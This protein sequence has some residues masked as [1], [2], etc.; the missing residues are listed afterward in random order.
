MTINRIWT[1]AKANVLVVLSLVIL[2]LFAAPN[3]I[4]VRALS[5]LTF[6][7]VTNRAAVD[8]NNCPIDGPTAM[9]IQINVTN[10][11]GTNFSDLTFAITAGLGPTNIADTTTYMF[12]TG[13][14]PSRYIASLPTGTTTR[15]Y[16]YVF[17]P[18]TVS[19]S[20]GTISTNIQVTASS[21]AFPPNVVS[22]NLTL[23]NSKDVSA[24]AG[25]SVLSHVIGAGAIPGQVIPLTVTYDLGNPAANAD[26]IINPVGARTFNAAC[27]QLIGNDITNVSTLTGITT[28]SD[29][30]LYFASGV[31]GPSSNTLT[32]IYYFQV[33]C[34]AGGGAGTRPT[35]FADY[36]SGGRDKY[37]GNFPACDTAGNPCNELPVVTNPLTI[38]KSASPSF[39]PAGGIV[40]YT[41]VITNTSA[42]ATKIDKIE[43]T[44]ATTP[45]TVTFQAIS[46]GSQVNAGNSSAVPL[47]GATGLIKFIGNATTSC[48]GAPVTCD[49]SYQLAAGSTLAL[50]YT[51]NVPAAPPGA[52]INTVRAY[53]GNVVLTGTATVLVGV[54]ATPTVTATFTPSATFTATNTATAT[55]TPSNT[56]TNTATFTPSNTAT[57]TATATATATNTATNTP[58]FT[59]SN[60][61][62]DTPTATLT[63]SNTAT[64]TPTNTATFTP[65][66]T[67]TNT[68]TATLTPSNTATD[69]PTNT[70][71]FTPSNT[72]T[73][74][75]TATL[76]PSNTATDTP[77]NTA[78][79]TP[80][81]TPTNTPT[82]TLTPSNTATDT[83]TNTPTFTPSNTATNTP[84][85]TLT[86]SSTATDTPT[87]TPSNTLT[88]T[89]T[90]TP[91]STATLTVTP[92]NT[93]TDTATFTAT[94][95]PSGTVT[96][97]VT[98]VSTATDTP[99]A[100]GTTVNTATATFTAS[101]TSAVSATSTNT[102]TATASGTIATA[103]NTLAPGNTPTSQVIVIDPAIVKLADLTLALPGENVTFTLT[104][105]NR[106]NAPATNVTVA[107]Q[108]PSDIFV[109]LSASTTKGSYSINGNDV[110]FTIGT[111]NPGEIVTM[112]IRTRVRGDVR[113][114]VDAVNVAV[115]RYSEGGPRT[116]TSS[117]T[118]RITSG[119]LPATGF[120][121]PEPPYGWILVG[122]GASLLI[123]VAWFVNKRRVKTS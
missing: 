37:T 65:S 55:S 27:F 92:V 28:A 38:T 31:N 16:Y 83:P 99:T 116:V 32:V 114:P 93:A 44:L 56:A 25:A 73:N 108:I 8:A 11:S 123:I 13:E 94:F 41:V 34:A 57:N 89:P 52:Y 119:S 69:T 61:P 51:A 49:G 21:P 76:T 72:A 29:N 117:A 100:T 12:G 50:I 18:C 60:T 15:L 97:T 36:L 53:I 58:T 3:A 74:T 66:N 110:L 5:G 95:T 19:G 64:D 42:F 6:T 78:T 23:T 121:P 90:V 118:V 98:P 17:V 70:A 30:Q 122:L 80:S 87:F 113:P 35:P 20:P 102:A 4:P 2:S 62:T 75:P 82:A 104:A 39:L 24:A 63:P 107:D 96:S 45:G 33:V 81:N 22:P 77:T 115:L 46:G 1:K 7:L 111:L 10:T 48:T 91:S 67:A 86:P 79:N 68:P 112:T 84:T 120:P 9:I 101:S 26:L 43:D 40:T 105:T 103:T 71:T 54:T 14:T 47:L 106:G 109:V 59:P 85:A 88:F